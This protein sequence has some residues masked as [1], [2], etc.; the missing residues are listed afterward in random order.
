MNGSLLNAKTRQ[1]STQLFRYGMIGVA[2]NSLG[3]SIYL[4][5][6]FLGG[7]PKITMSV[8]YGFGMMISF[9]A[10]RKLTF[11]HQGSALAAA[12]RY[13]IAHSFGF[14]INL[15]ILVILVDKMGFA[16]QWVQALAILIV[17]L[18]LFLT[19]R[20]FVFRDTNP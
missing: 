5:V 20:F 1:L 15:I 6:T 16:H 11:E 7:T 17:A 18:F 9:L 10:N 12:S 13:L 3:Y 14:L 4:L 8:L 2:S 19:M